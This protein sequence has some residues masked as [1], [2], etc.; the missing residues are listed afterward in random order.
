MM[1]PDFFT[2]K[3]RAKLFLLKNYP[4]QAIYRKICFQAWKIPFNLEI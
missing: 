1:K 4:G 3:F 2:S